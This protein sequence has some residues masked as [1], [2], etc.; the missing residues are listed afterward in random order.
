MRIDIEQS[1]PTAAELKSAANKLRALIVIFAVLFVA[2]GISLVMDF[3]PGVAMVIMI[4]CG[5]RLISLY[6]NKAFVRFQP[7]TGSQAAKLVEWKA[8]SVGIRRYIDKVKA[9]GR[10]PVSEEFIAMQKHFQKEQG[11]AK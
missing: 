3:N 10:E 2:S 7:V 6:F 5:A 9:Q 11:A 1:P 4:Y 8:K